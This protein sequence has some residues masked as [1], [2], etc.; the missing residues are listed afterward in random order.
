VNFRALRSAAARLLAHLLLFGFLGPPIG[1][2]AVLVLGAGQAALTEGFALSEL[3]LAPVMGVLLWLMGL[4]FAFLLGT[5][6]ALGAGVATSL[7][8]RVPRPAFA[9]LAALTGAGSTWAVLTVPRT[10]FVWDDW[11]TTFFWGAGAAAGGACGWLAWGIGPLWRTTAYR[12]GWTQE[13]A[14]LREERG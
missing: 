9:A 4:P 14:P 11:V 3:L 2:V 8:P 13:K 6:P 1:C 10:D 7:L 12:I 5:L